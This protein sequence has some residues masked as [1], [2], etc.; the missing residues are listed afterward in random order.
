MTVGKTR[1][2]RSGGYTA[3]KIID[4]EKLKHLRH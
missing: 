4:E 3:K 1:R 2:M